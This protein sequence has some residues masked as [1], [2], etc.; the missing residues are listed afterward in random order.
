MTVETETYN[1]PEEGFRWFGPGDPVP[2]SYIRQA[3]VSGVFTSL[4]QIPYGELWP[5]EIIRERKAMLEE[6]G[7]RWSVVESL[8]VH[9]AI[10]TGRGDLK[11]LFA[12]YTQSLR[13]LAEEDIHT[14]IYNFMPVLDWV[15]T[16]MRMVLP[17]GAI[18]MKYNPVHFAAFEIHALQRP[19]A[20]NDYS[21]EQREQAAAW[22]NSL[23]DAARETYIQS[24][25]DVFPGCKWGLSLD[26]LRE[27]LAQYKETSTDAL[28][29]NLSRFLDAV[30]PTAEEV[31]AR[32]AVHPDDPP[33]PVLGLPRIVS[34]A[35]DVEAL[36]N[37]AD[38]PAN[39]LCFC[40]GSFSAR[41]DNDLPEMMKRFGPRIH[42]VHLRSTQ[43]LPDGSFYEA[44]HLGGSVDM[45]VLVKNLLGEQDRRKAEGRA[46]WQITLRPDHGHVMMDDLAKPEGITP[47][48]SCIGRTRGLAELRGLMYGIRRSEN[49]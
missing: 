17:D 31:G 22:W 16:E 23:N 30:I 4:H 14:I 20:E 47:G 29:T 10:K 26:D 42:A 18:S 21:A 11:T 25:I 40:A 36:F 38:S 43:R 9:E 3:G 27:M 12:N 37:M 44:G 15:R 24:I 32:M 49:T 1:L 7:L 39:G 48:Y 46:D 5:R 34:T 6:A 2:L 41:G 35:D 19:G 13:N 28:R 45:Y 8:P 33:F